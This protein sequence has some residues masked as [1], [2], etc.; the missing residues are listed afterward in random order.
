MN[1]NGRSSKEENL[2]ITNRQRLDWLLVGILAG[3]GSDACTPVL[4]PVLAQVAPR[5][6]ITTKSH[7]S[8][9][10]PASGPG[11]H[12]TGG[13]HY[14]FVLEGEPDK[15]YLVQASSDLAFWV[16]VLTNRTSSNGVTTFVVSRED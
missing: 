15:E 13:D 5:L 14:R 3:I 2:A 16:T 1:V 4:M 9:S 7:S 12:E 8:Q 6:S 11:P 10:T